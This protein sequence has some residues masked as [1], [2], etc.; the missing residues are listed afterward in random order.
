MRASL[1]LPLMAL[2][3][4]CAVGSARAEP[5]GRID[6]LG[7]LIEFDGLAL[8]PVNRPA[9][10]ASRRISI[11]P[12]DTLSAIAAQHGVATRHL[13]ILNG[14]NSDRIQAGQVLLVPDQR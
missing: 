14:L 9:A 13:I 5:E 8:L 2:G 10:L 7:L 4:L 6:Q 3:L 12:G 11:H 1:S